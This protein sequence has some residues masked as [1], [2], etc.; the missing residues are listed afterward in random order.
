MIANIMAKNLKLVLS[1]VAKIF[2]RPNRKEIMPTLEAIF[3]KDD[4]KWYFW[5]QFWATD[6]GPYITYNEAHDAF[7]KFNEKKT[8][9]SDQKEH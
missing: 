3:L 4:G 7:M 2:L 8:Y 5:D 1:V 6:Y 9:E